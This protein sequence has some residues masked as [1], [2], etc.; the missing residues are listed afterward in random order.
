MLNEL[1]MG[2]FE[3]LSGRGRF[4]GR[5]VTAHGAVLQKISASPYQDVAVVGFKVAHPAGP[6]EARGRLELYPA[7]GGTAT[8]QN[9]AGRGMAHPAGLEPATF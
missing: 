1:R 6:R 4:L 8:L 9:V 7:V 3:S 2:T 5:V